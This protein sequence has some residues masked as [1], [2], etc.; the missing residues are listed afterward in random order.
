[1]GVSPVSC[2]RP[3][4]RMFACVGRAS[5]RR[6]PHQLTMTELITVEQAEAVLRALIWVGPLLGALIGLIAGL[7]RKCPAL[8]LWQGVAVGLLGPVVYGMWRFYSYT[9]RYDPETGEAGLHRVWVHA[10]NALIFIV[11]GV[12]L[13]VIYRR[14]VFDR[15]RPAGTD[16][17][18]TQEASRNGG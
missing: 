17:S 11:L 13:G 9:V 15:G 4:R 10:L 14:F 2:C 12:V 6:S 16:V 1:M 3:K 7:A 8:G 5:L 18:E